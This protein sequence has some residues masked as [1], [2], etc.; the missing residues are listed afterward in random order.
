MSHPQEEY[1]CPK[2]DPDLWDEK[3]VTWDNKLFIKESVPQFLHMPLPTMYGRIITRMMNA[4]EAAGAQVPEA[5]RLMLSHDLSPWKSE[6][7]IA[8]TKEVKGASNVQLSGRFYAK[9][10]DGPYSA[11]PKF[12]SQMADS[13]AQRKQRASKLYFFYTTCP[14]CAEK[15]GH[16]YIVI[17]AQIG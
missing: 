9:V 3:E 13:L 12:M 6:L 7:Y 2:F 4:L 15:F 16:N 17:F 1:C 8:A 5:D 11:I 14:K 10:F